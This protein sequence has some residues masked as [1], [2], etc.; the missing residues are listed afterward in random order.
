MENPPE[1]T[2]ATGTEE[3]T[4]SRLRPSFIGGILLGVA[5]AAF[6]IL[7]VRE[8]ALAPPPLE[9]EL[10]NTE[11][12]SLEIVVHVGGAVAAPG[13]YGVPANARLN[14]AVLTAGGLTEKADPDAAAM[15]EV[16]RDGMSYVVPEQ[17]GGEPV[18]VHLTGAVANSGLY[19]LPQGSRVLDG[20]A[21][22]GGLAD[23]ANV[24]ELNLAARLTDGERYHVPLNVQTPAQSVFVHVVGAVEQPGT[25]TLSDGARL[26]DAIAIAGGAAGEADVDAIDLALRL[27]DGHRYYIPFAGEQTVSDVTVHITGAVE[28]PGL[29]L[30]PAGTRLID[31]IEA[32]G[33]A[34]ATADVHALNLA[35]PI[36]DG[37][38]YAVPVTRAGVNINVATVDELDEVPGISRT[39]AQ[40][41]VNRRDAVGAF[42]NVDELLDVPGI[43]PATL[44]AIR[45][46]VSVN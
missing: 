2:R 24:T 30:L 35:R 28:S 38:R 16:L 4:L 46:F 17:Q 8:V 31:A 25:Y 29:Y 9:I 12:S 5:V 13:V 19:S 43:G 37:E 20:I 36:Q 7:I 26:V 15:A 14:D 3:S 1:A 11:P 21:A 18:V 45:P 42:V 23:D 34:L 40:A 32:A 27:M 44:A 10:P 41:I 33:G 6:I 22:A 39:V